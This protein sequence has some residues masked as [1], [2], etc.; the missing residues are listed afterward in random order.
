[1]ALQLIWVVYQVYIP[2]L[3]FAC[4]YSVCCVLKSRVKTAY[5]DPEYVTDSPGPANT[6]AVKKAEDLSNELGILGD[7]NKVWKLYYF[8]TNL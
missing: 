5:I 4:Y 1:M 2:Y 6:A 8:A 3:L 7:A